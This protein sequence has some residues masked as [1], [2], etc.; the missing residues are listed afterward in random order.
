MKPLGAASV[1]Q[2]GERALPSTRHA[3]GEAGGL[4]LADVMCSIGR[5]LNTIKRFV[6][7]IPC[8]GD[9]LKRL[10]VRLIDANHYLLRGRP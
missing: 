1:A 4:S 8:L 9:L 3:S 6:R 5:H 7:N 10:Q 2:T